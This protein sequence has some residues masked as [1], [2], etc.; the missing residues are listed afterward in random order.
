MHLVIGLIFLLGSL[1][2]TAEAFHIQVRAFH[3][4]SKLRYQDGESSVTWNESYLRG[5][6][7]TLS[8]T[9]AGREKL[10]PHLGQ[11]LSLGFPVW[12]PH[13]FVIGGVAQA[14]YH[15]RPDETIKDLAPKLAFEWLMN[16]QNRWMPF[17]RLGLAQHQLKLLSERVETRSLSPALGLAATKDTFGVTREWEDLRLWNGEASLGC[18]FFT[19][20]TTAVV[21][22]YRYSDSFIGATL[23]EKERGVS[24]YREGFAFERETELSGV[25][26]S[27]QELSLALEA[28][29]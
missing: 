7:Q 19:F 29:F 8:E 11:E 4:Q 17:A 20:P 25:R 1:G 3:A 2:S 16:V 26:L 14:T 21:L 9:E 6:S 28:G 12:Y 27:S 23:R 15:P 10:Y 5:P 18:K 24:S 13:L 22:E